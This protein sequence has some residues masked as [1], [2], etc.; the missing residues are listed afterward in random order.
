MWLEPIR[1]ADNHQTA[2]LA[3]L[4]LESS[5]LLAMEGSSQREGWCVLS[6]VP[7]VRLCY[8]TPK[9]SVLD[10]QE[11]PSVLSPHIRKNVG[12]Y[13]DVGLTET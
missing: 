6:G 9:Q 1:E 4:A 8:T 13:F 10:E 2:L 5:V 3:W 11:D 12:V 7:S